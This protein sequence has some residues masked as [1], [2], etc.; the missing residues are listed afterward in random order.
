MSAIFRTMNTSNFRPRDVNASFLIDGEP[1]LSVAQ[2]RAVEA[3]FPNVDLMR[4][5]GRAAAEFLFENAALSERI[6]LFAGPGNNGGDALACAAELAQA[7]YTPHVVMHGDPAKF[8]QDAQRAWSRVQEL[9]V[10]TVSRDATPLGHPIDADWI[11]DGLFGIGLKRPLTGAFRDAVLAINNA[12]SQGAKVLALDTPS[13]IDADTGNVFDPDV[14]VCADHTMTFIAYK[15]G[16]LTGPALDFVGSLQLADL[17]LEWSGELDAVG[18][19]VAGINFTRGASANAHKGTHGT[20]AIYG[21]ANGML[22]AVLLGSR[23]AMRMG[24]GKVKA[25][26]LADPFPQV[27]P[28]MPEV[29][30]RSASDSSADGATALVIGPGLGV[31]GAAVRVLKTQLKRDI[32]IVIDADALNLI[33]ESAELAKLVQSRKSPTII[34]PHPAEAGRLLGASTASVQSDRVRAAKDL[35]KGYRC[36]AVLKGAGTVI[37]D[38]TTVTINRTGNPLLATAG[39]GDVLAG[40]IGAL[41]A[42]G[43]TAQNAARVGVAFHGAAAD[44]MA[45]RGV[46]RAVASDLIAEL[47]H[48]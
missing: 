23:A 2:V 13:G 12:R 9:A 1:V 32:P 8:D 29:M 20:C 35:A 38:G 25:A 26:W 46:T 17:A 42:Q 19:T 41:L 45:E 14:C 44:A 3:Q 11:V 10:I 18:S 22:G 21:G 6:V 24:A 33:A 5:A 40:M 36:V 31:S 4:R 37:A 28:Q 47:A 15:V 48:L 16:L 39:T 30:M 43:Y 34:T 27:D 7:G